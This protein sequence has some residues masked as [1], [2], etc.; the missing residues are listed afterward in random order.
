M[1]PGCPVVNVNFKHSVPPC[2]YVHWFLQKPRGP[3]PIGM[4]ML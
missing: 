2:P 4:G 3:L 1:G